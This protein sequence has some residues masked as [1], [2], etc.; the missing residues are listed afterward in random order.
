MVETMLG[1]AGENFGEEERR[2]RVEN[3]VVDARARRVR[4]DLGLELG[5]AERDGF[6]DLLGEIKVLS[7]G[8]GE[9]RVDEMQSAQVVAGAGRSRHFFFNH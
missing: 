1:L 4:G 7:R 8:V 2:S 6:F 5:Q 9:K 3:G